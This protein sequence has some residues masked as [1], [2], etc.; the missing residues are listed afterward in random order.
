MIYPDG[1]SAKW[2]H[3]QRTIKILLF[4]TVLVIAGFLFWFF[5]KPAVLEDLSGGKYPETFR[6]VY[7][8]LQKEL[9]LLHAEGFFEPSAAQSAVPAVFLEWYMAPETRLIIHEKDF[10]P[11]MY[12]LQIRKSLQTGM[13]EKCIFFSEPLENPV[14]GDL[15]RT[16]TG[17]FNKYLARKNYKKC[18]DLLEDMFCFSSLILNSNVAESY[19]LSESVKYGK[20]YEQTFEKNQKAASFWRKVKWKLAGKYLFSMHG[21]YRL[22]CQKI[23]A[24]YEKIRISG[25][26][27]FDEKPEGSSQFLDGVAT[28]SVTRMIDGISTS[29][30]DYFYDVDRDQTM[31]LSMLRRLLNDGISPAMLERPNR[32]MSIRCFRRITDDAEILSSAILYLANSS[33]K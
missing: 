8:P 15:F 27:I 28:F 12:H 7:R 4:S 29:I 2:Y 6:T 24:D 14:P 33:D 3:N 20:L 18:V 26:H 16:L 11:D 1:R 5:N 31:T 32:K 21:I 22:E 30:T 25:I 23:M 10:S 19:F 17:C 13:R 9:L